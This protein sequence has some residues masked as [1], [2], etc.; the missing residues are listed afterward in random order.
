[1]DFLNGYC[2]GLSFCWWK[3]GKDEVHHWFGVI[4]K[5]HKHARNGRD[6]ECAP[7]L[8]RHP[9]RNKGAGIYIKTKGQGFAFINICRPGS[10]RNLEEA[11]VGRYGWIHF[12]IFARYYGNWNST[13]IKLLRTLYKNIYTFSCSWIKFY[14]FL[15]CYCL[16]H[17]FCLL[18]VTN[19][20][21]WIILSSENLGTLHLPV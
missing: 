7:Q 10:Q 16:L 12:A 15:R 19:Y 14:S 13:C 6:G 8:S 11:C 4:R 2:T 9:W 3:R 21:Y 20:Q 5:H 1:M 18:S 17:T